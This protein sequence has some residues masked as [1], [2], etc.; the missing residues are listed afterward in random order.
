LKALPA[1]GLSLNGLKELRERREQ[2]GHEPTELFAMDHGECPQDALAQGRDLEQNFA[3]VLGVPVAPD[4]PALGQPVGELDD[5]VMLELELP[6]QRADRGE[7][8]GAEAFEGKKK[9][10]LL[11]PKP[12][13]PGGLFAEDQKPSE[14]VAE[15]GQGLIF[16]GLR[17]GGG[18]GHSGRISQDDGE[19]KGKGEE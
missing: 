4:H 18:P 8:A 14:E 2:L 10:V 17:L 7:T 12:R 5:A 1:P 9:L 15:G 19:S 11:G 6:G 3:K 16:V 13:L